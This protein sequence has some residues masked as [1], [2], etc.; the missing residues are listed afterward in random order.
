MV[1]GDA[2]NESAD[3]WSYGV[4]LYEM[5]VG[6]PP[7]HAEEQRDTFRRIVKSNVSFPDDLVISDAAR[8]LIEQLLNKDN[9][10]RPKA[11]DI[12]S[13]PFFLVYTMRVD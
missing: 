9:A 5:L 1:E 3:M 4:L 10:S 7:F 12:L 13:H 11:S 8:E 2:H 6:F